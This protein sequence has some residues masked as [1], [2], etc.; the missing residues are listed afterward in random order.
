MEAL[1]L[2]DGGLETSLIYYQRHELPLFAAFPLAEG[3]GGRVGLRAIWEPDLAVAREHCAQF[4][5][6]TATWRANLD[7][8]AQLGYDARALRAVNATATR[9]ARQLASETGTATVNGVV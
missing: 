8:S 7:W 9:F 2:T 1:D 4:V 5:V 3:A 6:D